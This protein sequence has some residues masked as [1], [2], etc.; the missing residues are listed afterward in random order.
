M[1]CN[2]I[3]CPDSSPS[4]A[5]GD[6]RLLAVFEGLNQLTCDGLE[7]VLAFVV[8]ERVLYDGG[9]FDPATGNW[10]P[11]AIGVGIADLARDNNLKVSSDDVGKEL[12]VE[13]GRRYSST[14]H[15]NPLSGVPGEFY[16]AHR[17][18]DLRSACETLLRL[19]GPCIARRLRSA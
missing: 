1:T 19:R 9:N 17:R 2:H 16:R 6:R 14:F 11:L 4:S 13:A 18:S 10:C 5:T 8:E 15:L 7:R 12:I 3:N